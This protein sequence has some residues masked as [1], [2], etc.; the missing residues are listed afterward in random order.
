M[1][2]H[3]ARALELLVDH[4][5]HAAA[6]FRQR[7]GDD[8]QAAAVFDV[9]RRAE[10]ALGLV[11]RAR[12]HA[13]GERAPRGRDGQVVGARQAREAVHEDDDVLAVLD[14][15]HRPL[16]HHLR[17]ARMVLRQ[18]VE[19]GVEHLAAD[20]ALHVGDLLGP[21]VDEQHDQVRIGII[22]RD[23]VGDVL[24]Q[25]RLARLRLRDD[26]RALALADGRDEVDEPDGE[27]VPGALAL[28]RV[29]LV[30]EDG[31]EV[32]KRRA[33]GQALRVLAVDRRDVQ[34]REEALVL[35]G[36]ARFARD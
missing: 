35:L 17:H 7:G 14:Q 11:Q 24:E 32:L 16:E 27:V 13:A 10:E 34:Q 26:H 22:V 19:R 31:D 28:K 4:I 12:V 33:L 3:V 30:R 8:R 1:D 15:A 23:A 36:R 25:R 5:V 18:L 29:P 6:R 20:G 2:L 9:A 21:L